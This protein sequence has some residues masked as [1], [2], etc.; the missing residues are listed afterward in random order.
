[1]QRNKVQS[2]FSPVITGKLYSANIA[3]NWGKA[4]VV[5]S[6]DTI[7]QSNDWWWCQ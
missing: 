5:P 2:F 4:R 6:N 1:M 7:K 3:G